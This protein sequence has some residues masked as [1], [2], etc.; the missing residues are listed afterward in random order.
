M[1]RRLLWALA[2]ALTAFLLPGAALVKDREKPA[3]NYKILG[4][5][6]RLGGPYT[7]RFP[8][9]WDADHMTPYL[10]PVV[11]Q[12]QDEGFDIKLGGPGPATCMDGTIYVMRGHR[13]LGD[14]RSKG[15]PCR[16]AGTVVGGTVIMNSEYRQLGGETWY[17]ETLLRNLFPHE[18]GHALGLDH[19]KNEGDPVPTMWPMRGNGYQDE[20]MGTFT[21]ADLQ[22]LKSLK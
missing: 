8:T 4:G 15:Y 21:P 5:V 3:A 1:M 16:S 14:I 11:A 22:G 2:I 17:S 13:P 19:A 9:Q 18:L 6:E 10:L 12:L 20:R 7:I